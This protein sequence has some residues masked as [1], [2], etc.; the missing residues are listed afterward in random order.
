MR[1]V[2]IAATHQNDGKTTVSVGLIA[3][4]QNRG[5]RVGF[6]KPVGQRYME[7]EGEKI[8]EDSVLLA[9]VL[10]HPAALSAMSPIAVESSFTREYIDAPRPNELLDRITAAY[11]RVAG[12]RDFVVIEGTGHAGVGSVFD[13]SNARVAQH[14]GSGVILVTGGGIGRPIDEIMLNRSLFAAHGVPVLGV[15]LNRAIPDKLEMIRDYAG[16]GLARLGV[17][18]LGVI[19]VRQRLS[20]PTVRQVLAGLKGTLLNGGES[21]DDTVERTVI[22]TMSPHTALD[23]FGRGVLAILPGDRED[24][25]LAAMSSC[26]VARSKDY[27]VSG[28][29]LTRGIRPHATVMRLVK[30]TQIPMMLVEEE[31]YTVVSKVHDLTVKIQPNDV[32]KLILAQC[33]VERHVDVDR[34]LAITGAS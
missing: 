5:L 19:P 1:K 24:L 23:H 2:F 32:E 25:L 29:V 31:S 22:G 27:C 30:R 18:L 4:L 10:D 8:D 33:L 12:D 7:V 17:E 21:L 14:L 20:N 3:A 26:V 15:I 34:L 9:K 11:T 13:L 6:I 28:I 16:R